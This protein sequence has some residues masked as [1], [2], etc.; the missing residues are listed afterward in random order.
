MCLVL[1]CVI[2]VGVLVLQ[3]SLVKG[4]QNSRLEASSQW[5][6]PSIVMAPFVIFIFYALF[7][8]NLIFPTMI[9]GNQSAL[10][11]HTLVPALILLLASGMISTLVSSTRDEI[12][13]WKSSQFYLVS[14]SMGI[15]SWRSLSRLVFWKVQVQSWDRCLPWLFGELIVVEALFNAPG[16]G[17]D[18]WHY[19]KTQNISSMLEAIAWVVALY[20]LLT[21]LNRRLLA[22]LGRK[23]NSYV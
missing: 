4:R 7:R 5:Y 13:R 19:A 12:S 22:S 9:D 16:L 2:G 11:R 17:L 23:L 18:I 14:K 1:S 20:L 3:L 21:F 6:L 15:P 8:Y 10:F